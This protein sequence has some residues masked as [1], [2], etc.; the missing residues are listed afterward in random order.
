MQIFPNGYMKYRLAGSASDLDSN[1]YPVADTGFSGECRCTITVITD[2]RKGRYDGGQFRNASYSIT[3]N[4]EDVSGTFDP[5]AVSLT[6]DQKGNL[7]EFQVQRVEF[8][9]LTGTI[10]V[11][12]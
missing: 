6:H 7:G 11:W 10:E 9:N 2:N 12:V 3:C 4:M 1:G 5:T 8:Y